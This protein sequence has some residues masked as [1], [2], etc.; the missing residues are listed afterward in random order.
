MH[1]NPVAIKN[2]DITAAN[3]KNTNE[4]V[5]PV[6]P[7]LKSLEP[8]TKIIKTQIAGIVQSA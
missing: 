4:M 2:G 1:A 7:P 5:T 6:P 3:A 8:N